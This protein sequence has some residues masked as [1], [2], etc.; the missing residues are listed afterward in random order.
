MAF[1]APTAI[2]DTVL[3]LDTPAVSVDVYNIAIQLKD[4]FTLKTVHGLDYAVQLFSSMECHL[5]P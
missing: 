2:R 4:K 1:P 3:F 5:F